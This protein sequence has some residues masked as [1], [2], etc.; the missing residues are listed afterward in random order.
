MAGQRRSR[1]KIVFTIVAIILLITYIGLSIWYI[2]D[3]RSRNSDLDAQL[4]DTTASLEQ[5]KRDIIAQPA[6]VVAKLQE[7][8]TESVLESVGKLYTLP[9]GENPTVATVQ[10]IDKLKDQPFFSG[11]QN[12]DVLIVFEESS[13]AILY[14]PSEN[15]LVKVG[16]ISVDENSEASTGEAVTPQEANTPE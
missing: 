12:G 3:L 9:E 10:D 5:F 7:E 13:Q 16:P 2:L 1:T 15:R 6:E 4:A 14:R 8:T 11:A